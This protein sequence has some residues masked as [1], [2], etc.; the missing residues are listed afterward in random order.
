MPHGITQCYLPPGRGDIH[1]V[2][3]AEAAWYSIKRSRRDAG[4]SW[5]S[6]GH[7]GAGMIRVL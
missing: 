2:T 3:P 4:L 6:D 1:A 7:S 5:P